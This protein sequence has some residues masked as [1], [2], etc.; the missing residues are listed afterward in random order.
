VPRP[1]PTT[2]RRSTSDEI[3]F[4]STNYSHDRTVCAKSVQE[5][6][7]ASCLPLTTLRRGTSDGFDF[8]SSNTNHELSVSCHANIHN[9]HVTTTATNKRPAQAQEQRQRRRNSVGGYDFRA[10]VTQYEK[11]LREFDDSCGRVRTI[12]VVDESASFFLHPRHSSHIPLF[13]FSSSN[14]RVARTTLGHSLVVVWKHEA[15]PLLLRLLQHHPR[16]CANRLQFLACHL[17]CTRESDKKKS[18]IKVHISL[19]PL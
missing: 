14:S 6:V 1:I 8:R 10:F 15:L 13:F 2:L 7:A 16:R 5:E 11:L 18:E 9:G 4:K 19:K 12:I 17:S 3:D